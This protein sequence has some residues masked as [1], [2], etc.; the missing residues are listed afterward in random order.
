MITVNKGYKYTHTHQTPREASF[1]PHLEVG[2]HCD[3]PHF[4]DES[5]EALRS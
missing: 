1:N 4:T 2:C 5:T 3:H